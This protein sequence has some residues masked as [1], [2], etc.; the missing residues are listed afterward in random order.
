MIGETTMS[1]HA[2]TDTDTD[3]ELHADCIDANGEHACGDGGSADGVCRHEDGT[4]HGCC[5]AAEATLILD[6]SL[7]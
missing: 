5:Q 2:D 3:T 7:S 1:E 4:S 6:A